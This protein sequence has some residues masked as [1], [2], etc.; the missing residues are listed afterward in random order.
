MPQPP[1][2]IHQSCLQC[3]VAI[4]STAA[5]APQVPLC[6]IVVYYFSIIAIKIFIA[7]RGATE[8]DVSA[9]FRGEKGGESGDTPPATTSL[10]YK[11]GRGEERNMRNVPIIYPGC[12]ASS[13]AA[14]SLHANAYRLPWLVVVLPIIVLPLSF[15]MF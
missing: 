10:V 12:I 4:A 9:Y 5:A 1:P 13:H 2:I 15:S 3:H 14:D 7:R 6:L 11:Q 8:D